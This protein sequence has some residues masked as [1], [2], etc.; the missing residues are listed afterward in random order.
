MGGLSEFQNGL[1]FLQ[2]QGNA[3]HSHFEDDPQRI[4]P[5]DEGKKE[6]PM[7]MTATAALMLTMG[8]FANTASAADPHLDDLAFTLK[9]QAA[10]ACREVRYGFAK[11]PAYPHLYKDFYEL[12]TLADHVHDVAHNHG[13]LVHLKDDVDEMDALFHQ[14]EELTAQAGT[15]RIAQAG[16]GFIAVPACGSTVSAYHL[17]KLQAIMRDMED[18]LH[19]LQEDLDA[20][21]GPGGVVPPLPPTQYSPALPPRFPNY[22]YPQGRSMGIQTRNGKVAF[23]V[24]I[25]N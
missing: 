21:L 2:R 13:D 5:R 3:N 9:Q 17:R 11:T 25:G 15:V 16:G 12:Y 8:L 6:S 14:V 7:K 22:G 10:L 23:Q 4:L 24:R 19:H 20:E 18:T 1:P